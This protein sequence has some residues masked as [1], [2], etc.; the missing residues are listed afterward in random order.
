LASY[1]ITVENPGGSAKRVV[2]AELDGV[3]SEVGDG[4]ARLRL[5]KDGGHHEVRVML[6][7]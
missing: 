2:S 5:P 4:V 1:R 3:Q 7:T 6:G